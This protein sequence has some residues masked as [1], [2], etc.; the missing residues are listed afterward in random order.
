MA[1]QMPRQLTENACPGSRC[2][3]HLGGDEPRRS[4]RPNVH[5]VRAYDAVEHALL[6]G[7]PATGV[8][9]GAWKRD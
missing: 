9:L 4:G 7:Q 6:C 5:P 1:D 3:S 8:M 2:G